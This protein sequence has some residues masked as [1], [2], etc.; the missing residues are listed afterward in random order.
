LRRLN[1]EF[2]IHPANSDG[3]ILSSDPELRVA[4]HALFKAREVAA[5]HEK[6]WVL[7]GD[8]LVYGDGEFFTK[9][10]DSSHARYMLQRLQDIGE[11][12]V[13]TASC[14][15]SPQS[16]VFQ[17]V[18][19]AVV[20]FQSIPDSELDV[21]LDGSEWSDK[22]GAYAIQGWAGQFASCIAGDFETIV[23]MSEVT[24][25]KLFAMSGFQFSGA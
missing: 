7:A 8:T 24:V 21:Y 19:H 14:L 12:R 23:G 9:P 10:D 13:Y 18:E 4:G 2:S 6:C 20:S 17:L 25:K 15:L 11:H 22:A 5:E 16:E 3:P 1:I